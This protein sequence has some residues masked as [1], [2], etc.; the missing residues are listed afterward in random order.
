MRSYGVYREALDAF[1]GQIAWGQKL[2]ARS[3]FLQHSLNGGAA[4][5]LRASVS[6]EERRHDGA[7]FTGESLSRRAVGPLA[8]IQILKRQPVCDPSC[9]AGDL[10][11][12]WAEFLPMSSS[13]EGTLRHWE[14]VLH[15]FDLHE[16]FLRVAKRRLVLLAIFRGARLDCQSPPNVDSLFPGLARRDISTQSLRLPRDATLL[17]NPPFTSVRASR[18]CSWATGL[19]SFAAQI[20]LQCLSQ[21]QIGQHIVAILPDVLR[22]GSRY[23]RWR[24]EVAKHL[25]ATRLEVIGRFDRHADVDVFILQGSVSRSKNAQIPWQTIRWGGVVASD[26]FDVSVGS[27]VPHR[28]EERGP[29]HPFLITRQASA[30]STL[31]NVQKRR[32]FTGTT[33]EPPFVVVRRTSSPHDTERGIGTLITGALAVAVENHLICLRPVDGKVKTCRFLIKSLRDP[34]TRRWLDSQIRCRHLT[35]RLLKQLPLWNFEHER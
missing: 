23:A 29:W 28:D 17:L 22:S 7:F 20:V 16:E 3:I 31:I 27:V 18:G 9:G 1:L 21:C 30:W 14:T 5:A 4:D 2:E 10:L 13:L 35:V 11:L 32:R 12:R 34:K 33:V 25:S 15:G 8:D 24:E 6:T 26:K 19:V